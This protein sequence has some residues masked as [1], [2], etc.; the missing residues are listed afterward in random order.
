MYVFFRWKLRPQAT[1]SAPHLTIHGR[2]SPMAV[3]YASR[4]PNGKVGRR[5]QAGLRENGNCW[6]FSSPATWTHQMLF[7]TCYV[8]VIIERRDLFGEC[9]AHWSD[10]N[11]IH[12]SFGLRLRQTTLL[13][14][15]IG[16]WAGCKNPNLCKGEAY[17]WDMSRIYATL[18]PGNKEFHKNKRQFAPRPLLWLK[19][20]KLML[21]KR[22]H[23]K[24]SSKALSNQA[25]EG[26][27][28]AQTQLP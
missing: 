13:H 26:Q 24:H 4:Y 8:R 9:G 2:H 1:K 12:A 28:S 10:L 19:T 7:P 17:R 23:S 16:I 22:K 25:T 15:F 20:R 11:T 14:D 3:C 6:P 21:L 18:A 27:A 5:A